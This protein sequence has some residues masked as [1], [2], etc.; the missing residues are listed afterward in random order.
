[1]PN[2]RSARVPFALA[3]AIAL[4]FG[5]AT[6]FAAPARDNPTIIG[7]C[8]SQQ[9]CQTKCEL[10]GGYAGECDTKGRCH[11]AY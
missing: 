5:A 1:M 4:S 6:A 8:T 9:D 10:A 7:T 11:C 3:A 2:I